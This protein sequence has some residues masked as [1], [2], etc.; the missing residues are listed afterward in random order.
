LPAGEVRVGGFG[1]VEGLV[2]YLLAESVDV[3][4]DATHPF[5]ARI[6]ANAVDAAA[7]AGVRLVVLR[8]RGWV[9]GVGDRWVVV[10]D[11]GGAARQVA[12]L[13]DG[14]VVFLALG[15][16]EI[17][18]FAGD[19]RH[20]FVIR[21]VEAPGGD[22][23][24]RHRI[25]L[26]RGPFTVD[27]ELGLL[28]EFGVGVVVCRNSGEGEAKLVAAR[29]LGIPVIMVAAPVPV[30]GVTSVETVAEVVELLG[31]GG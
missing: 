2:E 25:V 19:D 21:S 1:G 28:R 31:R 22:L 5:A 11:V 13:P 29:E 8:R 16:Q 14:C 12:G 10:G 4:I 27:G 15:R 6:S 7:R 23:P 30:A 18:V 9:P 24:L 3:L 20:S 26:G 17:G